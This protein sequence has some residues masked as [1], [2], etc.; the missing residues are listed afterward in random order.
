MLILILVLILI[1]ILVIILMQLPV[2]GKLELNQRE[3]SCWMYTLCF[4]T[5]DS[6]LSTRPMSNNVSP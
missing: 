2:V 3:E 1:L 6:V 4:R 5:T